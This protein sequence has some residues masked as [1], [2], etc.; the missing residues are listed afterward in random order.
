[1]IDFKFAIINFCNINN[2][3]LK[4][5]KKIIKKGLLPFIGFFI[6]PAD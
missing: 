2:N 3:S 1:M 4:L 5:N 6:N